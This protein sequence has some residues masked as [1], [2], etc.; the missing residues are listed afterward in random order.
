MANGTIPILPYNCPA[1][2][3]FEDFAGNLLAGLADKPQAPTRLIVF[4]YILNYLFIIYGALKDFLRLGSFNSFLHRSNLWWGSTGVWWLLS[5]L[6]S[7]YVVSIFP[8]LSTNP[9]F[10]LLN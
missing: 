1:R 9:H 5:L 2:F 3:N 7:S 6:A 10:F 8:T 4:N